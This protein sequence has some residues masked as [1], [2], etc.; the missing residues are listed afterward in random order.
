MALTKGEQLTLFVLFQLPTSQFRM[1]MEGVYLGIPIGTAPPGAPGTAVEFDRRLK[2]L[3]PALGIATADLAN[4]NVDN[5][6]I[7]PTQQNPP[8]NRYNISIDPTAIANALAMNFY[9]QGNPCPTDSD[10]TRMA[11]GIVATLGA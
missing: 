6:W 10:Q 2:L 3:T 8:P 5:I 7:D 1:Q 4:T 9:Q 11:L